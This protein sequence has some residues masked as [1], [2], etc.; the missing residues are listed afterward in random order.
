VNAL[1][2]RA[3]C[4]DA[5]AI[6][7]EALPYSELSPWR[8][9]R[10]TFGST[11]LPGDEVALSLS[12]PLRGCLVFIHVDEAMAPYRTVVVWARARGV[13]HIHPVRPD[14]IT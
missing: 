11:A 2:A 4:L 13:D 1:V 7:R 10:R 12:D 3:A 6:A 9:K 5:T 8:G 14:I